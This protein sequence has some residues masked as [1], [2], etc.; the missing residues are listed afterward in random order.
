[1][2]PKE[3]YLFLAGLGAFAVVWNCYVWTTDDPPDLGAPI[4][5]FGLLALIAL[6]G[7]TVAQWLASK[8]QDKNCPNPDPAVKDET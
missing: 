7:L 6:Y 4:P 5:V 3:R 1:M 8:I 2:K